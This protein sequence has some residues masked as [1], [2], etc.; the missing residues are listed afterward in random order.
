[1]IE[2]GTI[3]KNAWKVGDR[4]GGGSFSDVFEAA[5]ISAPPVEG[6]YVVKVSPLYSGKKGSK[7]IQVLTTEAVRLHWEHTV[8]VCVSVCV[9]VY[10]AEM[11]AIFHLN[12][13]NILHVCI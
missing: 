5:S 9:C 3:L 12:T 7:K 1:M 6:R 10:G 13:Y 11:L 8:S 2:K 4:L